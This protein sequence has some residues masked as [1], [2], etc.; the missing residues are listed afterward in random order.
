MTSATIDFLHKT[1]FFEVGLS[2]IIPTI[3][4]GL[5]G[6]A[7]AKATGAKSSSHAAEANPEA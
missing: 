7:V 4:C 1:P 6:F 2:W 3:I 5:I